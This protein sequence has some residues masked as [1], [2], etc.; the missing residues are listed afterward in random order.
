[1]AIYIYIYILPFLIKSGLKDASIFI[2]KISSDYLHNIF[3]KTIIHIIKTKLT[4]IDTSKP[5]AE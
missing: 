3:F 5:G 1:M 2:K 4:L